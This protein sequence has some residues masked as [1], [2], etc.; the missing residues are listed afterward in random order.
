MRKIKLDMADLRVLSFATDD[1]AEKE[2]G[3][4][5][6]HVATEWNTC[7]GDTCNGRQTC[8]DSC[9]GV[10]GTYYCITDGSCWNESCVNTCTCNPYDNCHY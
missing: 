1:A 2:R 7:E 9:D 6:G 3:T 5:R 4:V 8:W 10:C